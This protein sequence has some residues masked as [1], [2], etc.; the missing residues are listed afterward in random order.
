M[1]VFTKHDTLAF[2]I[3]DFKSKGG[4]ISIDVYYDDIILGYKISWN[5]HI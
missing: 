4:V 1:S 2:F 5:H 3:I